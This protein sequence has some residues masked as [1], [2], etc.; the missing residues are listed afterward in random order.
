VRIRR[1]KPVPLLGGIAPVFNSPYAATVPAPDPMP[2]G[3]QAAPEPTLLRVLERAGFGDAER[4]YTGQHA[5]SFRIRRGD[6]A[7]FVVWYHGGGF[8][9]GSIGDKLPTKLVEAIVAFVN[10]AEGEPID[11][12]PGF[13][14]VSAIDGPRRS[15]VR[16]PFPTHA[17]ALERVEATR[18]LVEERD[19]RA[20]WYAWGTAR[21]ETD[22]GKGVLDRWEAER[23][24]G[25]PEPVTEREAGALEGEA[26]SYELG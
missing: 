16:G 10:G 17:E 15:M 12:R 2:W 14:Y 6:T 20:H 18:R 19:P 11:P 4:V 21:S 1:R 23:E 22:L 8:S 25:R 3:W 24:A 7:L 5:A 13:Y 9:L 26:D